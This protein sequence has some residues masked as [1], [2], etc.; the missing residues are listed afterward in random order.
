MNHFVIAKGKNSPRQPGDIWD[1]MNQSLD[2]HDTTATWEFLGG[3]VH[4]KEERFQSFGDGV[5]VEIGTKSEFKYIHMQMHFDYLSNEDKYYG[6]RLKLTDEKPE[7]LGHMMYFELDRSYSIPPH[8]TVNIDASLEITSDKNVEGFLTQYY[9]HNHW[10]GVIG[11]TWRVRNLSE[12]S[13]VNKDDLK[14]KPANFLQMPEPQVSL[15]GGDHLAIRG[16]F[17]SD[18]DTVTK[19][20]QGDHEEALK[21]F[22]T[23]TT[24]G[25]EG[26]EWI[27]HRESTFDEL[28]S[29]V[30]EKEANTIYGR[31]YEPCLNC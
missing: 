4:N 21:I 18:S 13:L 12:W 8:S 25:H 17:Q 31:Y 3:D 27:T 2:G 9:W 7:K 29:N 6:L 1:C 30:P 22:I 15:R 23:Y 10:Y 14:Y 26:L 19:F 11:S 24:T 20:G 16:V 5:G 28:F